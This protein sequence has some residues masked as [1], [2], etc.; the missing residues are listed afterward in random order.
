MDVV[1]L[2]SVSEGFGLALLEALACGKP[3]IAGRVDGFAEIGEGLPGV[4]LVA[5]RDP[6]TLAAVDRMTR[7]SLENP[8][9]DEVAR[10]FSLERMVARTEEVYAEIL[11][12]MSM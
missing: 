7:E 8:R 3:V 1:V 11:A 12:K 10:L 9:P 5:P 4:R 2:P 6:V